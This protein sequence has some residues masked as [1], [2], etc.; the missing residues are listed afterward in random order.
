LRQS[1]IHDQQARRIPEARIGVT[2]LTLRGSKSR[3]P[4]SDHLVDCVGVIADSVKPELPIV[5]TSGQTVLEHDHGGHRI[6]S[7]Q[8][9][10]VE[11]LDSQWCVIETQSIAQLGEASSTTGSSMK[12]ISPLRSWREFGHG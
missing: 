8:V 9:G 2:R 6:V 3:H 12:R 4:P 10:N 11:T 7:S 5:L 1:A